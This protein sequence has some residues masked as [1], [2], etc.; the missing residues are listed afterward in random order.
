M[1]ETAERTRSRIKK[2]KLL[3]VK[4]TRP[5]LP[6]NP[7][8]KAPQQETNLNTPPQ[9]TEILPS[10]EPASPDHFPEAA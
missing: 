2:N 9:I 5:Q 4:N 6:N 1:E 8:T 3:R 10:L 7:N